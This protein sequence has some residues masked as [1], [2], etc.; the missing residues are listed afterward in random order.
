MR[1][2]RLTISR[3]TMAAPAPSR[4]RWYVLKAMRAGAPHGRRGARPR[5]RV[6]P[7]R[8][9]QREGAVALGR[10]LDADARHQ[11][12]TTTG[13]PHGSVCL[14][15]SVEMVMAMRRGR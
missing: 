15:K 2:K 3:L 10:V 11:R 14:P 8:V 13:R 4:R 7:A 1:F 12:H 5:G 9:D 6:G